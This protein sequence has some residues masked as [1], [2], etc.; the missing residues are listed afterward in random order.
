MTPETRIDARAGERTE[1]A[2]SIVRSRKSS[3]SALIA[4]AVLLAAF[5]VYLDLGPNGAYVSTPRVVSVIVDKI[6][7]LNAVPHAPPD[8]VAEDIVWQW[9][10]PRALAAI[11]I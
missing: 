5:I 10:I 4:A 2:E 6:P 7:L 9:R 8:Q 11:F 3:M 1:T